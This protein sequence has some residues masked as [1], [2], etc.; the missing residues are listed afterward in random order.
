MAN[1]GKYRADHTGGLIRPAQLV[2]ATQDIAEGKLTLDGFRRVEDAAVDAALQ[3]QLQVGLDV[4]SDGEFRRAQAIDASE[5]VEAIFQRR[6]E[7]T[8]AEAAYLLAHARG[9]IKITLP[10]AAYAARR[11]FDGHESAYP[12]MREL[13]LRLAE[14]TRSEIEALAAQGVHYIQLDSPGYA[15]LFNSADRVRASDT[16]PDESFQAYL[17]ADI[18]TL[19]GIQRSDDTCI[20]VHFCHRDPARPLIDTAN[21]SKLEQMFAQLPADRFVIPFGRP[22]PGEFQL[23]RFVPKGKTVALGLISSTTAAL[24]DQNAILDRI[25]QAATVF[26]ADDLALCTRGG[27]AQVPQGFTPMSESEERRKLELLASTARSFWGFEL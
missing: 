11:F 18:A 20:A 8:A 3:M 21:E 7:A 15:A 23:L 6:R 13:G 26:E 27:F 17:A 10:S 24:E 9:R 16:D 1:P 22:L 12:G 4:S 2:R 14:L 25:D 5:S 19:R